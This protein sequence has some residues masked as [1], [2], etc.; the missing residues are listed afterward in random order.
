MRIAAI[1]PETDRNL[2]NSRNYGNLRSVSKS[3]IKLNK[4]KT[5]LL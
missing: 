5:K 3:Y 2:R 1:N 4:L